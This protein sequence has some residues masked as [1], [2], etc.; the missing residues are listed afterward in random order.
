MTR[1]EITQAAFDVLVER[2]R[3]VEA[4]GWT[5]KHDDWHLAGELADAAACYAVAGGG[6]VMFGH[7]VLTFQH[8][9]HAVWPWSVDAWRP[10]TD[11]DELTAKRRNLVKAGALILAEIERL[12]RATAKEAR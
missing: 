12:D 4:K 2:R 9:G 3:Q 6:T 8:A 1:I 11:P 5:P 7:A 10:S